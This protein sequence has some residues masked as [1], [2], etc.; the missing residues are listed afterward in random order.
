MRRSLPLGIHVPGDSVWHRMPVGPKLSGLVIVSIVVVAMPGPWPACIALAVALGIAAWAGVPA[1]TVALGVRPLL[2]VLAVLAAFQWW[3]RGWPTA[4]EVVATTVALV[5]AATTFTAT[6]QMDALLDTIVRGLA[7]FRRFGV[8]P[9]KVA[10]AFSLMITSIPA[11]FAIYDD[12]R[13]AARARGLDRSPRA[14][15]APMVIRVVAHAQA[16]GDA[17]TARGIGD[18]AD[19]R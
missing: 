10:L 11:V 8:D 3:Q 17:L 15:L 12:T 7:P 2:V 4:V 9:D 13:D 5:V 18:E 1:R 6:T 16:T 19:E 14:T